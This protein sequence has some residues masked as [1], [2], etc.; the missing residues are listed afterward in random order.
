MREI[1][2]SG[3]VEGV[4]GNHDSYS[5]SLPLLSIGERRKSGGARRFQ[6]GRLHVD[7]AYKYLFGVGLLRGVELRPKLASSY[8]GSVGFNKYRGGSAIR[9]SSATPRG[10]T[11]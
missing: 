2:L 6:S 7:A 11:S 8:D 1:R 10:P 4:M 9:S 5:D 3:S